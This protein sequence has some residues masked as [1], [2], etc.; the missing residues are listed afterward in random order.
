VCGPGLHGPPLPSDADA[1]VDRDVDFPRDHRRRDGNP[2][3]TNL[4]PD[5]RPFKPM[6][7]GDLAGGDR[8]SQ[9]AAR[10]PDGQIVQSRAVRD[11]DRIAYAA[12]QRLCRRSPSLW[13]ETITGPGAGAS[14]SSG[15]AST[16][17]RRMRTCRGYSNRATSTGSFS[18]FIRPATSSF[19]CSELF[20]LFRASF[21]LTFA[22]C[23]IGIRR[24]TLS[25]D[26][27]ITDARKSENWSGTLD[28]GAG[29][30]VES[31]GSFGEGADALAEGAGA[32]VESAGSFGEGADAL[33]VGAGAFVES[34]GSFGAGAGLPAVAAS[35]A[36]VG[37][38]FSRAAR[39]FFSSSPSFS[40]SCRSCSAAS[41][42]ARRRCSS[43]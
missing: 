19:S 37:A 38:F 6:S 23:S 33:A 34:A 11:D 39:R 18:D 30:F 25:A 5:R 17:T 1:G 21:R 42:A 28:E 43:S 26:D 41:S 8:A 22:N 12:G 35:A 20:S 27:P 7:G 15:G 40:L 24:N 9:P 29:A 32:F 16:R 31:A 4:S 10:P 3:A 14:V 36:K 13:R 2:D